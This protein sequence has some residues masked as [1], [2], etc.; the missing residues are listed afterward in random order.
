MLSF[1]DQQKSLSAE[2]EEK[3][4]R[5]NAEINA[6]YQKYFCVNKQPE[7]EYFQET[8]SR[9]LASRKDSAEFRETFEE[10]RRQD[11]ERRL[12]EVENR[13]NAAAQKS[14]YSAVKDAVNS[15]ILNSEF[16]Q[17]A[18]IR[19]EMGLTGE[20]DEETVAEVKSAVQEVVSAVEEVNEVAKS[21][22]AVASRE[23]WEKFAKRAI[24]LFAVAVILLMTV[25]AINSAVINGMDL[26]YATLQQTLQTLQNDIAVLRDSI[27]QQ[28]SWESVFA[29]IR[30]N[31]LVPIE[32]A[33]S[34]FPAA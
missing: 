34:L 23:Q 26:E 22:T 29:Y 28:T 8:K 15:D 19:K 6:N 7:I 27:A 25:I 20:V 11:I 21:Q 17:R 16:Y 18:A 31:G 10:V 3:E 4:L 9:S 24:A 30:E 14:V 32:K 13:K 12:L 2:I 5:H 33:A 1:Q